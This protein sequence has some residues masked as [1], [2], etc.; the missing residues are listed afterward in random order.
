MWF[1]VAAPVV[2]WEGMLDAAHT[3]GGSREDDEKQVDW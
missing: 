3:L 1:K 2:R